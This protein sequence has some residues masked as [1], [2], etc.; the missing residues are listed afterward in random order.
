MID[1]VAPYEGEDEVRDCIEYDEGAYDDC[2]DHEHLDVS[3][4]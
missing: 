4:T 2:G 1:G 3:A